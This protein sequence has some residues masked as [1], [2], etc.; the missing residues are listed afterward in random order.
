M[1]AG[2]I[3]AYAVATA[4]LMV[5][6][7]VSRGLIARAV[8]LRL[9]LWLVAAAFGAAALTLVTSVVLGPLQAPA[10]WITVPFFMFPFL[11]FIARGVRPQQAAA[12]AAICLASVCVL[13]AP[14][15]VLIALGC[16]IFPGCHI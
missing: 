9:P 16:L 1:N 7:Y 8:K 12:A 3:Y 2:D 11:T 4:L 10:I 6:I 14:L 5:A 15:L 13:L